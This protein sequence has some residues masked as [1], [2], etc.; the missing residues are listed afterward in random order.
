MRVNGISYQH[1][2]AIPMKSVLVSLAAL[3]ISSFDCSLDDAPGEFSM[4][5]TVSTPFFVPSGRYL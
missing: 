4:I 1:F 5:C 3:G 2:L